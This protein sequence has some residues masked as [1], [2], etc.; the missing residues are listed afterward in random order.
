MKEKISFFLKVRGRKKKKC[1]KKK[2]IS[3]LSNYL[4]GCMGKSFFS[5][6]FEGEGGPRWNV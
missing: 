4:G 1:I 2:S 6:L 3:E 5:F